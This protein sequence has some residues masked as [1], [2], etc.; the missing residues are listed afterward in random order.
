[1][2]KRASWDETWLEVAEVVGA[3][4]RCVRAQ[5][6]AVIVSS[7]NRVLA[8]GYNGPPAGKQVTGQCDLWCQRAICASRGED[9]AADYTDCPAVHAE[10][11]AL[12]RASNLWTEDSPIIYVNGVTCTRCAL[13]IANSGVK[14]I[15]MLVTPYELK[16]DPES[17]RALLKDYEIEVII[18]LKSE[19]MTTDEDTDGT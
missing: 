8:V 17:T 16:R 11:N 13:T 6:G 4:S 12:L 10:M 7:D 1:M 3:K 19:S 9:V 5:Y 14:T 2:R 15:H 18:H